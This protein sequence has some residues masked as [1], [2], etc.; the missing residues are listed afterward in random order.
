MTATRTLRHPL[1][2]RAGHAASGLALAAL[3]AF[4]APLAGCSTESAPA[5]AATERSVPWLEDGAIHFPPAFAEREKLAFAE[6]RKAVLTPRI[7]VTGF[8]TWDARRVAAVGARIEGRLRAI[9]K[10]EG[11]PVSAGETLAELESVEL[12]KAQ[13]EVLKARAREQ[14]AKLD[15]DRSRRLADAKIEPEREA[16]HTRANAEAAAAER[17]AA[18]KSVEALGG[19]VG[20]ELGV[21]KLRSP[22]AGHVVELRKKR[23]E[24]VSP[25]DTIL[26]VADLSRVWVELAVFE[27]DVTALRVDDEVEVLLPASGQAALRGK[28]AHVSDQIDQERRA[29]TVRVEV[30][31]ADRALRPGQSVTARVHATGPREERLLVPKSAVTRIDGQPTVFVSVAEGRVDPRKVLLGP[32]DADDVAI[33]SGLTAGD[34]VVTSGVLAL[35]AEVFR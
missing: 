4:G 19:T 1:C 35:K 25:T 3:G 2:A 32:E 14:V 12:G 33:L 9:G 5:A 30:P 22:L 26:L 10:V 7:D 8:I 29:A 24:V 6:A 16:E 13:A 15:A 18:E 21:L 23:G 17:V 20:G 31:N 34:R 28:V 27:R 11:E